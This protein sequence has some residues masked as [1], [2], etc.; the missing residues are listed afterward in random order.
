MLITVYQVMHMLIRVCEVN[1]GTEV[2][3]LSI[4]AGMQEQAA[5]KSHR[6][7]LHVH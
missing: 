5:G 2:Q 3:E 4:Q 6:Q 7:Q 1:Q